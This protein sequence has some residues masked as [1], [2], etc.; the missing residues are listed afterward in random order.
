MFVLNKNETLK[1]IE[2]SDYEEVTATKKTA[3][4]VLVGVSTKSGKSL[5][6]KAKSAKIY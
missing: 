3:T 1:S 5:T 4:N 6:M 2:L